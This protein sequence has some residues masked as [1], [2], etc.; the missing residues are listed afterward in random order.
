MRSWNSLQEAWSGKIIFTFMESTLQSWTAAA[1]RGKSS[2][3]DHLLRGLHSRKEERT[4]QEIISQEAYSPWPLCR[5]SWTHTLLGHPGMWH[6]SFHI[7]FVCSQSLQ[8]AEGIMLC[9]TPSLV[10]RAP[11]TEGKANGAKCGKY[12]CKVFSREIHIYVLGC[13]I[14]AGS[15]KLSLIGSQALPNYCGVT[16]VWC[17]LA[18]VFE[19]ILLVLPRSCLSMCT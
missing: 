9:P 2:P 15:K 14:H 1:E 5:D 18:V 4:H 12:P 13:G 8:P 10:F 3:R 19:D 7:W 17:V 6:Y 11:I 16:L